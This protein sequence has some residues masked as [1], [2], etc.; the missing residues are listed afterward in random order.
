M[1]EASDA[2]VP[3]R[4]RPK[5]SQK[6]LA[7][8]GPS[9]KKCFEDVES[10]AIHRGVQALRYCRPA[11]L[12]DA[13]TRGG[14]LSFQDLDV[15]ESD[16]DVYVVKVTPGSAAEQAGLRVGDK[17]WS[18]AGRAV[19]GAQSARAMGELMPPFRLIFQRE[20]RA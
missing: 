15:V 6:P 4:Y 17:L 9:C 7:S 3:R 12:R 18:A 5:T 19:R 11:L 1:G 2:E 13:W 14:F 10:G 16:G 8:G 20:T